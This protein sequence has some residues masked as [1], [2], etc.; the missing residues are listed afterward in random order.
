ME[1]LVYFHLCE[2]RELL[3][4]SFELL[5]AL[6]PGL[7]IDLTRDAPVIGFFLGDFGPLEFRVSSTAALDVLPVGITICEV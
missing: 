6:E 5:L 1:R 3:R 4:D 7:A 2:L